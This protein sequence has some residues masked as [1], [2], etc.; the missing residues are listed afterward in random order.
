MTSDLELIEEMFSRLNE[1]VPLNAAERRNAIGGPMSNTIRSVATHEFFKNSVAFSNGRYQHFEV[2]AKLLLLSHTKAIQ[3]TK[4]AYLDAFVR[5]F[6]RGDKESAAKALAT[7][8]KT[9]LSRM[10]RVFTPQ[11]P[12]LKTQAMTVIYYLLLRDADRASW[13]AGITRSILAEFEEAR[14]RN[15]KKA[16]SDIA[17]ASYDLLEFDRMHLQGSNDRVSIEFRIR[18]LT[19][20]VK[21]RAVQN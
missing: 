9:T 5:E 21:K 12:L 18:V 2:A 16:E 19:R 17:K 6:K 14:A 10:A 4:R 11:D 15:R 13:G 20:F 3:D 7:D 1:G 8:V